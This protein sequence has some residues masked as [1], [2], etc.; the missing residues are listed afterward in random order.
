MHDIAILI[1]EETVDKPKLRGLLQ[2]K[3]YV[4]QKCQGNKR[5]SKTEKIF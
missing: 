1:L 2:N 4:L 3:A 5:Q